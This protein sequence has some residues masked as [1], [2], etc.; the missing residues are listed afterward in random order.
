VFGQFCYRLFRY[1][2]S[3]S[4]L[5]LRGEKEAHSNEHLIVKQVLSTLGQ[6]T[7]GIPGKLTLN[8]HWLLSPFIIIHV[9]HS[10]VK[11]NS[12]SHGAKTKPHLKPR[13]EAQRKL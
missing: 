3:S 4:I 5:E 13:S 12:N 9:L 11:V 1:Q 8:P 7:Q 6:A 2:L 10:H